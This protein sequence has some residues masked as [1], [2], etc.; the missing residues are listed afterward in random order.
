QYL[1]TREDVG[2]VVMDIDAAHSE[3]A[4]TQL[5]EVPGTLRSRV[6]F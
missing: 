1:Q 4:L 2:Y 5:A 6:L 3:L